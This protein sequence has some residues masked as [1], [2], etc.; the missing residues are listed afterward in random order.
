MFYPE[1][2]FSLEQETGFFPISHYRWI[3]RHLLLPIEFNQD[4]SKGILFYGPPGN[5]KTEL[6]H[7]VAKK[8][9][10]PLNKYSCQDFLKRYLGDGEEQLQ[11]AFRKSNEENAILFFDEIDAICGDRNYTSNDHFI[12]LVSTFLTLMNNFHCIV[13]GATNRI[14]S[15]DPAIRRSGRFGFEL[16][17]DYPNFE[18]RVQFFE[19]LLK[20]KAHCVNITAAADKCQKYSYADLKHVVDIGVLN[21]ISDSDG[22]LR[23]YHLKFKDAVVSRKVLNYVKEHLPLIRNILFFGSDSFVVLNAFHH[24]L[25][26][27]CLVDKLP[28]YNLTAEY[29]I[30][31]RLEQFSEHDII[32]LLEY[33]LVNDKIVVASHVKE[34]SYSISYFFKTTVVVDPKL[35][36]L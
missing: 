23:N 20:N 4:F 17:F 8:L 31:N 13:I 14:E 36:L 16:Y 27:S 3:K 7:V 6:A 29:V 9:N 2:V 26:S 1:L 25:S 34:I 22:I 5:G 10:K 12:S 35:V 32:A 18:E 21:R 15:L 19:F 28:V 11:K 24:Y 30:V 33:C